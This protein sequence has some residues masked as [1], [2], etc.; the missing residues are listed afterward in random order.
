MKKH[1]IAILLT[2]TFVLG[3]CVSSWAQPGRRGSVYRSAGDRDVVTLEGEITN[4][5]L[6]LA[7]FKSKDEEYTVDLGPIWYWKQEDFKLTKGKVEIT[8]E[9]ERIDGEWHLYPHKITQGSTTIVLA[10]GDG[11][12]KWRERNFRRGYRRYGSMALIAVNLSLFLKM[13]A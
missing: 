2:V 8:G 10:S 13:Q 11:V 12:P 9:K 3:L 1:I 5:L 4:V 7:K 6:P